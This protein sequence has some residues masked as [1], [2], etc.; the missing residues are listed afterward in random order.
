MCLDVL[1]QQLAR[2]QDRH[3]VAG[4]KNGVGVSI[5]QFVAAPHALDEDANAGKQLAHGP[6]GQPACRVDAV[7]AQFDRAVG[8]T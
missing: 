3:D 1:D 8:R 5:D 6:A 2:S 7:G 4:L